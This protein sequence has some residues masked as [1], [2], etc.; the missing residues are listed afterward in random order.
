MSDSKKQFNIIGIIF[1]IIAAAVFAFAA[2]AWYNLYKPVVLS[3]EDIKQNLQNTFLNLQ[4]ISNAQ[5]E[6]IKTDWDNDG[7]KVFAHYFIHLWTSVSTTGDPIK[8]NLITKR[9]GFALEA[10][11]AIN[12][13]YFVDLHDMKISENQLKPLDYEKQW[14]ILATPVND[15][16]DEMVY[17]L[18]D[19]SGNIYAKSSKYIPPQY[20]ENPISDG[21]TKIDS[22]QKLHDF[23]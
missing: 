11:R 15:N 9:L 23:K 1:C 4:A 8:V 7:K 17:L 5:S 22:L 10:S 13:Y 19:N 18:A 16:A 20:I 6:Y 14:A 12:G 2:F 21:W 3:A